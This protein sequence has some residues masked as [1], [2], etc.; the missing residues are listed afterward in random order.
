M[1]LSSSLINGTTGIVN[2][3]VPGKNFDLFF[4]LKNF[5]IMHSMNC[6]RDFQF[7][8]LLIDQTDERMISCGFIIGFHAFI[9]EQNKQRK[10]KSNR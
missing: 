4:W 2:D 9:L 7:R 5:L 1:R 6:H 10:K 8:R 3:D